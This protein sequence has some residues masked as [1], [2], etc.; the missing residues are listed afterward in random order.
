MLKKILILLISN[1]VFCDSNNITTTSVVQTTPVVQISENVT[2]NTQTT[3]NH[4]SYNNY[5]GLNIDN[6]FCKSSCKNGLDSDCDKEQ[7]CFKTNICGNNKHTTIYTSSTTTATPSSLNKNFCGL[8]KFNIDCKQPCM[9]GLK[10][11]C[12]SEEYDCFNSGDFC[13]KILNVTSYFCGLNINSIDCMQ[14]CPKGLKNECFN[15]DFNCY[16][17]GNSCLYK[18]TEETYHNVN[19]SSRNSITIIISILYLNILYFTKI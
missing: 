14:P 7:K 18:P 2:K 10:S 6:I 3:I 19:S 8:D 12:R 5:C 16:D 17:I 4:K 1:I 15:P 9:N 11:D 13:T